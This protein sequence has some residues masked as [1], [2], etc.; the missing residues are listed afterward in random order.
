[1][2][3][4]ASAEA[5]ARRPVVA[6]LTDFGL[7]DH[8]VGAIKGV[9][10]GVCPDVTLID[11]THQIPPQDIRAG[12]LELAAAYRFFPPGTIFVAVVD[13]GVG[14]KRRALAAQAGGYSF[15]GPDNG[16]FSVVFSEAPP[17]TIVELVETRYF[18]PAVS[19]TFEGRDRFAPVAGWLAR[20]VPL[21]DLGPR[22]D[23][24]TTMSF[25]TAR[26]AGH[27]TEGEVV[28]VDRFGNLITNITDVMLRAMDPPLTVAAGEHA[29]I[30]VVDTYADTSPGALCALVGSAGVLEIAVNQGHA[31]ELLHIGRGARVSV[32]SADLAE[33]LGPKSRD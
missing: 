32:V 14:S 8:Y 12:A 30:A 29:G 18:R 11:I 25:T 24:Y 28:R 4:R 20:G 21:E 17:S 7:Q 33:G 13:P 26:R 9:V 3:R 23:A 6:L 31:A 27:V 19:R 1:M 5:S 2:A 22:L 16:I 15:V 10:L